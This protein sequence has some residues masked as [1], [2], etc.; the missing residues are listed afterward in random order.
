MG[1]VGDL[2]GLR[3]GGGLPPF[4]DE[5]AEGWGTQFSGGKGSGKSGLIGSVLSQVPKCEAPGAPIFS[6]CA[7]FSRHR[8]HPPTHPPA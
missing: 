4:R 3:E 7:H 5:T 2:D 8:G 1:V 6:G